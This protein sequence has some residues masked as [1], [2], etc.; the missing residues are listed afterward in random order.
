MA[1]R[2]LYAGVI[3]GSRAKVDLGEPTLVPIRQPIRRGQSGILVSPGDAGVPPRPRRL[4]AGSWVGW[5][6][7]MRI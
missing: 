3:P 6:S 5:D 7:R 2:R 4:D 1:I